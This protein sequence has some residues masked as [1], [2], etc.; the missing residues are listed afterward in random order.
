MFL[1]MVPGR[2]YLVLEVTFGGRDTLLARVSGFHITTAVAGHYGDAPGEPLLPLLTALPSLA[3]VVRP[4][5]VAAFAL[6]RMK[7][8]PTTSSREACRVAMSGSYLVVF[9]CS[10]PSS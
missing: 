8:A 10:R 2:P 6:P 9:G 7:V 1:K 3:G 5:L 4:L